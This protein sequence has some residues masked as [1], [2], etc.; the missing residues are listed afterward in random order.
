M[1]GT[2]SAQVHGNR[3]VSLVVSSQWRESISPPD[4]GEAVSAA[5]RQAMPESPALAPAHTA[6]V[7]ADLS[8]ADLATAMEMHLRWRGLVEAGRRE[9][10]Q[11]RDQGPRDSVTDSQSRA[12]AAF[13]GGRFDSIRFDPRWLDR[14]PLQAIVDA[15]FEVLGDEDLVRP[16]DAPSLD[17]A[18][19]LDAEIRQFTS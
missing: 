13:R 14:A 9:R 12:I 7:R 19:A 11:A 8:A 3:L 17:A 15:V 2:V 5:I 18:R 4:L 10:R 6:P 1:T 16:S